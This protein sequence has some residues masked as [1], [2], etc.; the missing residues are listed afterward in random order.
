MALR[1]TD[2][3]PVYDAPATGEITGSTGGGQLPAIACR[4]VMFK[5][6]AGNAGNV[7]LGTTSGITKTNQTTTATAGFQL[8]PGDQT[9]WLPVP[10]LNVFWRITDNAADS[11]VYI[12]M[13]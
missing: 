6:E 12:L 3:S 4:M 5:A 10:N 8:K 9:P 13:N 7:Y 11:L 2:G 1:Q